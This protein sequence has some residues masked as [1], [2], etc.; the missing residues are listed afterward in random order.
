M[1]KVMKMLGTGRSVGRQG[2]RWGNVARHDMKN[3]RIQDDAIGRNRRRRTT[4][5]ADTATLWD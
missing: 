4:H 5:V 1:N 3:L 2:V